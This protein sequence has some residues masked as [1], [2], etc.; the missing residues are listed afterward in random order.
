KILYKDSESKLYELSVK[1]SVNIK[2]NNCELSD[3]IYNLCTLDIM[4]NDLIVE[5][6][7]LTVED[8]F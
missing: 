2:V 5:M 8:V 3:N 6:N 1:F 7:E 4:K